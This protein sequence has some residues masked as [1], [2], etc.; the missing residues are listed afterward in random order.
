MQ[1]KTSLP[2]FEPSTPAGQQPPHWPVNRHWDG[3]DLCFQNSQLMTHALY[4]LCFVR[5]VQHQG[6]AYIISESEYWSLILFPLPGE[7]FEKTN[8][9]NIS[10][11]LFATYFE[12][13]S[14]LP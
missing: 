2:P 5:E 7:F 9:V 8:F 3:V 4:Q 12:S 13:L 6:L 11:D 10:R 14:A 1:M